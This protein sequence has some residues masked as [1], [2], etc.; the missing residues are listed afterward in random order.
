MNIAEAQDQ[1]DQG[2]DTVKSSYV[3]A[4][5]FAKKCKSLRLQVCHLIFYTKIFYFFILF[6][7]VHTS[8]VEL[9]Y[10]F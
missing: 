2:S 8:L 5:S 7:T 3:Q 10:G 4:M 6:F 1:S 9:F